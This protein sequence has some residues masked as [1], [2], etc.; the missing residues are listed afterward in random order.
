MKVDRY[1]GTTSTRN[2]I[3]FAGGSDRGGTT[4]LCSLGDPWM[5]MRCVPASSGGTWITPAPS[6]AKLA[7]QSES[8]SGP[9][10]RATVALAPRTGLPRPSTSSITLAVPGSPISNVNGSP[11]ADSAPKVLRTLG[12]SQML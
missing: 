5:W 12:E 10:G 11:A 4:S 8:L 6:D 2:L 7:G 9:S 3:G 1:Y